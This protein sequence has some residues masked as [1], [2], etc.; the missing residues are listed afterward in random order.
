LFINNTLPP[1]ASLMSQIYKEH[2][3]TDGF[4]YVI[5]SGESTFG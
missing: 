1:A 2:K 5:Y 3:D 4:L